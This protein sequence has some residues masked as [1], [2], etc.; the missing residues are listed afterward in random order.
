[1]S[2]LNQTQANLL[3]NA[4]NG[5]LAP[6]T[7]TTETVIWQKIYQFSQFSTD[8]IIATLTGMFSLT[9]SGGTVATF[10]I[11]YGGTSRVADGTVVA[12][13]TSNGA[14]AKDSNSGSSF[15]KPVEATGTYV[16]ITAVTD[17]VGGIATLADE[18]VGFKGA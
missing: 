5:Q 2:E 1:M 9:G 13:V 6:V 14:A 11:R 3:I 7:G 17:A 10:R 15:S 16:K 18:T 4:Q 8:N 12:T